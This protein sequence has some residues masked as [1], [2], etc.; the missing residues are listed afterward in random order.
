MIF[1][2]MQ[3]KNG[4][5]SSAVF[6]D[7]VKIDEDLIT[8][9][10]MSDEAIISECKD[11][12]LEQDPGEQIRQV[13]IYEAEKCLKTFQMFLYQQENAMDELN[14]FDKFKRFLTT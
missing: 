3:R 2:I 8:S 4:I 13:T 1:L 11:D 14:D 5:I 10:M 6:N 12:D 7:Y 9:D